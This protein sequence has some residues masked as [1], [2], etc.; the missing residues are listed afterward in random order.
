MRNFPKLRL[1]RRNLAVSLR[2]TVASSK[3]SG[4]Y[5]SISRQ[6][7]RGEASRKFIG[8]GP[9]SQGLTAMCCGRAALLSRLLVSTLLSCLRGLN[10]INRLDH[11]LD[12]FH[13]R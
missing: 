8:T 6:Q 11:T 1:C 9:V 2:L 13:V 3:Y 4:G 12:L 7:A 10:A 5:A